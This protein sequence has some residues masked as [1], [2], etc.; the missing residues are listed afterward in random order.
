[1]NIRIPTS[2]QAGVLKEQTGKRQACKSLQKSVK[3]VTT[4][5]NSEFLG[6]PFEG[7]QTYTVYKVHSKATAECKSKVP[8]TLAH[9]PQKKQRKAPKKPKQK[10]TE[11]LSL[12]CVG[13]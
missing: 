8:A 1:M 6:L 11:K 5:F 7:T 12:T 9:C 3:K 4:T 2:F 10:P 13:V